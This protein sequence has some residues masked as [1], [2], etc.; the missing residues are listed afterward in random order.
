MAITV[1]ATARA[2]LER[3][4][5]VS[6][7]AASQFV[8]KIVDDA[9]P[10]FDAMAGAFEVAKTNPRGAIESFEGVARDA[11]VQAAQINMDLHDAKPKKRLRKRP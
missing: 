1:S 2:S 3:L 10:I 8:S 6:G 7:I 9:V 5:K 11:L 4:S